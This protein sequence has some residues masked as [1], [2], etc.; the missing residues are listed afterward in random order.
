M[1]NLA[2]LGMGAMGSRL[3]S[4]LLAAGHKVTVWNRT[5]AATE[6]LVALG[7]RAAKT[8]AE[9]AAGCAAVIAVVR[10]DAASASV[11]LGAEGALA[12]MK[13]DAIGIECSTLSTNGIAGI[14]AAFASASR[15]LVEAPI[16]GS[17]PQAE[18]G[19]LV[20]LLGGP[21]EGRTIASEILAAG[22]TPRSIGVLGTAAIAKLCVNFL[23]ASQVAAVAEIIVMLHSRGDDPS[24]LI[25]A[26]RDLPVVSAAASAAANGMIAEAFAPLF[27]IEL[28]IKDLDYFRQ[29]APDKTEIAAAV[30]ARYRVAAEHGLGGANIT[31]V[32]KA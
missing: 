14:S 32:V 9:A 6:S 31:A 11:W 3:A 19:R 10:D 22:G 18:A 23:L 27:P 4:R 26:I 30:I 12:G 29:L 8:P 24:A 25:E 28:V 5:P 1:T 21:E 17:R 7:A 16:V 2:I 15:T 20:F 13:Q